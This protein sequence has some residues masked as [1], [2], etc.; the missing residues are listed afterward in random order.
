MLA[1]TSQVLGWMLISTSLPRLPAAISSVL[2]TIQPVGSMVLG[3]LLLG[4]DATS[5]QLLG[6]AAILTGLVAVASTRT[7]PVV[8]D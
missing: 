1:L 3:A 7:R 2:L 6:V 5:L 4:E 8:V